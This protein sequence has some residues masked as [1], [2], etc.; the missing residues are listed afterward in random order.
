MLS[1]RKEFLR[2]FNESDAVKGRFPLDK[3]PVIVVSSNP[4][5]NDSLRYSREGAADRLDYLSSNSLH[6]TAVD[7]GHE[8]HLYQ[9][10]VLISAL[11]QI[12]AAV[13]KNI[14]LSSAQGEGKK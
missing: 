1:W 11:K 9:P 5:A 12:I 8:I 7:S 4:K 13:R 10:D 2:E 6:I 14:P 3:L